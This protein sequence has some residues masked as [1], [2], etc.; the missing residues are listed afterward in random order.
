MK[1]DIKFEDEA[2]AALKRG[3]DALADAVKVTLGPK[4]RN[5]VIE[6]VQGAPH[7]TKDG[8]T[9]ARAID[10][11]D[12]V[13]NMGAQMVKQVASRTNDTTGDGTTTATILAQAIVTA[14]FKNVAAG[15][16]PMDLKKGI[17]KAVNTVVEELKGLSRDVGSDS[18][19]I[20]H[21]A[22]ISAN[23]DSSIGGI[24]AEAVK[25]V[26]KDGVIT[27]EVSKG[28]E[29]YVETVEGMEIHQGYLS[30]YFSTDESLVAD[31]ENPYI[32]IHDQVI[33]NVADIMSSLEISA[34]ENRPLLVIAEDVDSNALNTMVLNKVKGGMKICAIKS[35]GFGPMKKATLEDLAILTGGK[36]ISDVTGGDLKEVSTEDLGTAVRVIIGK[37]STT[38]ISGGGKKSSI[39]KRISNI[40]EEADDDKKSDGEIL[41]LKERA[42]KLKGGVAILYIGA[43]TEVELLEKKD[44][45]DDSLSAT[46]AAVEEGIIP[47][48]GVAYVRISD[49]LINLKGDNEDENLGIQIVR[50]AMLEP[51]MQIVANAGLSGDIIVQKVRDGKGNF[52]YNARTDE[53]GDMIK[54]GVIDPTKVARTAL[55]NA[56]SIASLLL[57]TECVLSDNV[58]FRDK[59]LASG[60]KM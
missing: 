28:L 13:E 31:L 19:M 44:R 48:G 22:T 2:R 58:A 38:I 50:K 36:V 33:S 29:T 34:N 42:A 4:G 21:V 12:P 11:I 17:E 43:A 20:N 56:A 10:L 51:L 59:V 26:G 18:K 47:G 24:I 32:L 45:I 27:I 1:K 52:G 40:R 46:R 54:F 41:K 55:E 35:P 14:G 57:T 37:N 15:A 39:A 60:G 23:N 8:V 9:V 7:V 49:T 25:A 16:N 30:P 6:K 5:V 3:V 53:F